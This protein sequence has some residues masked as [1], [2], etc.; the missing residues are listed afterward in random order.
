MLTSTVKF[1]NTTKIIWFPFFNYMD[2]DILMSD[3]SENQ[4]TYLHYIVG[5]FGIDPIVESN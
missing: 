2:Y 1:N 4:Q 5:E 3:V